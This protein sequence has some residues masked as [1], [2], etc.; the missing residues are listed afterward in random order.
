MADELKKALALRATNKTTAVDILNSLGTY[1]FNHQLT[2]ILGLQSE[3]ENIKTTLYLQHESVRYGSRFH[4]FLLIHT[5][6]LQGLVT[7]IYPINFN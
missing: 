7:I 1:D 3:C 5:L 6:K 4:S 2:A